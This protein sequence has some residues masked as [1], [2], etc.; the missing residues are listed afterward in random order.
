MPYNKL[1]FDYHKKGRGCSDINITRELPNKL[2]SLLRKNELDLPD[3]SELDV[4]RHYTALSRKNFG[5]ETNFYP[6][7]SCTMKYNPKINEKIASFDA[8]NVHPETPNYLV[9]G[10]LGI[11][12]EM[13]HFLEKIT[14]FPYFSFS[15]F[16]GAHGELTG[17]MIIKKYFEVKKQKR[18][19]II[20]PDSAH[21]TNPA[22][23]ALA[24]FEIIQI[25]SNERGQIDLETLKSVLKKDVAGIMLT[26]PNTT[27][28][29]EEEILEISTLV[30]A[31]GSLLYY[32]GA[33][34]NAILGVIRPSDMGFDVMHINLHKTF[35]TPHGGGGPGSGVV[36]VRDFLKDYLPAPVV[37]KTNDTYCFS[38]PKKTIGSVSHFFGNFLV[39]IKAYAY[40]LSLGNKIDYVGKLAVLNS[41]YLKEGL[42]DYFI[43]PLADVPCLHEFVFNGLKNNP[44]EIR[45]LDV[46][47]KL[48]DYGYHAPT[49]YFPL[50]FHEAMMIE[51]TESENVE[52]L[53]EF[54]DSLIEVAKLAVS[55]PDS[56]KNAPLTREI[57]RPDE[58]LAA[59]KPILTYK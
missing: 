58:V 10:K 31:N 6:L 56:L 39:V 50:V 33:N 29:F 21:G 52:T 25:K 17:L 37:V 53:D 42:K 2:V 38:T 51:P 14:G 15:P 32:D 22:S 34:L 9:Q 43:D 20:V 48:L 28:V 26:N 41:R 27:G 19:K 8:F 1:I 54:R 12:F 24:G 11:L 47:K 16:A 7:G 3:V 44:N 5:V 49:I 35:S 59:R 4:V 30:H 23:A 36:G 40:I 18:N 57:K 55:D 45:T 46:A 13:S